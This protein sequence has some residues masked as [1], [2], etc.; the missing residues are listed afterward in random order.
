MSR[1]HSFEMKGSSANF[2]MDRPENDERQLINQSAGDRSGVTRQS[3]RK[4]PLI[5][6]VLTLLAAIGGFLFGYDTGVVSGAMILIR[7]DFKLSTVWQEAIVSVTIGAAALFALLGGLLNDTFGRKPVILLASFVFTAGAVVMGA[8]Q[9]KVLLL[10]GRIVVGIGIGLASMT[11]PMYIAEAAPP[12]MRGRLVTINNMFIT[13]G[14]FVAS[15]IDG[16]FSYNKQDGWRYMLGLAGVPSLVQFVG[17]LFLP[18]SPRWLVQHGDNL[19]AKMVLKRMRGVDNVDE[20]FDQIKQSFEEEQRERKESDVSGPVLLRMLQHPPTRRALFVGCG[21]QMFQQIAGINTVMYYSASI[22]K[23][24]GVQDD[25]MAIWLA[26]VTA[27]VNFI[28]TAV[29]VYLVEKVGRRIL[30]LGSMAGV[31][32][33]LLVL[34]IAFWFSAQY[35]PPIT[36]LPTPDNNISQHCNTYKTCNQCALDDDCGYCFSL[37]SNNSV[38][39]GSCMA[40]DTGRWDSFARTGRCAYTNNTA[41]H[42]KV[43]VNWAFNYCPSHY[44]WLAILGL[45]LYLMFFAPGMGPMPWTINSEIYPLWARST[46]NACSAAT[47]WIFNLLVSMT[48]L[49]LT[50]TLTRPGT[51]FMYS[52]L[53]LLGVI[54]IWAFLPETKGRR[55]EDIQAMFEGPCVMGCGGSALQY[56]H[57]SGQ[58]RNSAAE[59]SVCTPILE[60]E[61]RPQVESDSSDVEEFSR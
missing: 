34:A 33:S 59:P 28:F 14:Q 20:E 25:S 15:V 13:G 35:S 12:E 6:Y 46:G 58:V 45:V 42:R 26:A 56:T 17:F 10:I 23:M 30:A 44:S 51:F 18:E 16:A 61:R 55:L 43:G 36:Y 41:D 5:L 21:L 60:E 31:F 57:V 3:A 50:E 49:T 32:L 1:E 54:F 11:V 22:I 7:D 38:T 53:A 24:A 52:G 39:N 2:A 8:A 4:T 40:T 47:N 48:F 19:M 27:F 9:S 29:G 37:D